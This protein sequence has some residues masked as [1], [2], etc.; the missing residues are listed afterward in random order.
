MIDWSLSFTDIVIATIHSRLNGA[1]VYPNHA[2]AHETLTVAA[3]LGH[4]MQ[5]REAY[6]NRTIASCL[7]D[8]ISADDELEADSPCAALR[9]YADIGCGCERLT[10]LAQRVLADNCAELAKPRTTLFSHV[11]THTGTDECV[12]QRIRDAGLLTSMMVT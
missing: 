6:I 7:L 2:Y 8:V 3:V 1:Y 9:H 11:S 10:E 5:G 12:A 4:L